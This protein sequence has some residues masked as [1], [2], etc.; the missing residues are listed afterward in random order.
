[1]SL[2]FE[3][4]GS[5]GIGSS[6]QISGRASLNAGRTGVIEIGNGCN[7][8]AGVRLVSYGG[9]I[10]LGNRVSIGEN[11]VIYGH[12]DVNIGESTAIGPL[13]FVGSQEHIRSDQGPLRNTGEEFKEV[14]IGSGV[15]IS[16]ACVVT[17]GVS[18]GDKAFIGA[19]SL[20]FHSVPSGVLA[21]GSPCRPIQ[22]IERNPLEGWND[23]ENW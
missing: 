3:K 14:I 5:V 13:T 15:I 11:T 17:A 9:K 18:I 7:I 10:T 4:I 16:A 21:F 22:K 6:T 23:E 19:G 8:K 12:G 1:M 2:G 20:V